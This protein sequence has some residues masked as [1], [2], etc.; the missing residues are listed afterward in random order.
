MDHGSSRNT[1]QNCQRPQHY[2]WWHG[3]A[4][5]LALVSEPLCDD[6]IIFYILNGLDYDYKA[7][8]DALRARDT[9]ISLLNFMIN[10]RIMKVF[11]DTKMLHPIQYF[12]LLPIMPIVEASFLRGPFLPKDPMGSQF[13]LLS[14]KVS[15]SLG[16]T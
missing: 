9:P 15:I 12:L 6:E 4:D 8:T 16:L 11:W 2:L 1:L 14:I 3:I 5:S 7:I 10:W 13:L